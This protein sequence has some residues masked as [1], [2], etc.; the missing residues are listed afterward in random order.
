M[1]PKYV[2]YKIKISEIIRD[3][4]DIIKLEEICRYHNEY[5]THVY[6]FVRLFIL[7]K[8]HENENIPKIDFDF[9]SSIFKC[10]SSSKSGPKVSGEKL[11]FINTHKFYKI[12]INNNYERLVGTTMFRYIKEGRYKK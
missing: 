4:T 7:K 8:Y 12:N 6:Q 9:I 3:K 11:K 2:C 5:I 10:L 1:N